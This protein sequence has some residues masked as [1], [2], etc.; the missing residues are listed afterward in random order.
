FNYSRNRI[1][2]LN[3]DKTPIE[4]MYSTKPSIKHI[5]RFGQK[6]FVKV[7]KEKRK[8]LDDKSEK[9]IMVGYAIKTRGYRVWMPS[10][11]RVIESLDVKFIQE[12]LEPASQQSSAASVLGI[13][14]KQRYFKFDLSAP[15]V[16]D[17]SDS[18]KT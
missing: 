17:E 11:G 15:V 13:D 9:G 18:K 12:V 16:D 3:K 5:R 10:Q 6:C 8:K 7:A 4:L 2:K 14:K 1:I